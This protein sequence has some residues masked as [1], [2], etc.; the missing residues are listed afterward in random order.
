MNSILRHFAAVAALTLSSLA[1]AGSAL[2]A[3]PSAPPGQEQVNAPAEQ[4][5]APAQENAAQ[6]Q[7]EQAPKA[8]SSTAS[9]SPTSSHGINSTSS[10]VKPST[11][12]KKRTSCMTGGSMPSPS[13]SATTS[14]SVS[15]AATSDHSKRY[16]NQKTAAQIA[17][18]RGGVGIEVRGPGNSQPHKVC[19]KNGN[20]V[21]VHA[22]KNYVG[23]CA[24]ATTTTTTTTTTQ[25]NEVRT[26]LHQPLS[27]SGPVPAAAAAAGS[28]QAAAAGGVAG[29]AAAAPAGGAGGVAGAFAEIG[30]VA[31]E[32]LPFTGFPLWAVVLIAIA[33]V[34]IGLTLRHGG[35]A[36]STRVAL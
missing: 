11:D 35:R 8:S 13:C 10:G 3:P 21:D 18:S 34:V 6:K 22:V 2:A 20:W 1:L 33:A 16:G 9:S 24:A 36:A 25:L 12:T 14:G 28:A 15:T 30:G 32:V 17:V 19:G 7:A 23:V 5:A 4:A 26:T 29:V 31:G 27:T